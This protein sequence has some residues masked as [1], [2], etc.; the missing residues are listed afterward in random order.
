MSYA[1][2]H[3]CACW[4]HKELLVGK[5]AEEACPANHA[6]PELEM[7]F[8]QEV[9]NIQKLIAER[10]FAAQ[11]KIFKRPAAAF[12]MVLKRPAAAAQQIL[13]KPAASRVPKVL[14]K[15]PSA[16]NATNNAVK[17]ISRAAAV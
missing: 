14:L 10:R 16:G 7:F 4:I 8:R 3:L 9:K 11:R 13:K 15:R 5:T 2:C 1:P 6:P 17:G 12:K